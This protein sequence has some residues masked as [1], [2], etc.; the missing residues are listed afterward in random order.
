MGWT[1]ADHRAEQRHQDR[2]TEGIHKFGHNSAVGTSEEDIWDGASDAGTRTMIAAGATGAAVTLK[3]S[4][5]DTNDAMDITV[6]GLGPLF[7]AQSKTV[8]LNGFVETAIDGTWSRVY[9]AYQATGTADIAGDVYIYE[10]DATTNGVPDTATKIRAKILQGENQT[11]MAAYTIPAGMKG[12]V[13]HI[14]FHASSAIALSARLL[15]RKPG[16]NWRTQSK[17]GGLLSA[18]VSVRSAGGYYT[19]GTD[20][21]IVALVASSTVAVS[22]AFDVQLSKA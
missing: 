10:D 1:S 19:A 8:T 18:P 3:I 17:Y 4:S 2:P 16:V 13:S 7:V 11:L 14:E 15:A 12:Y 22:A 5:S 20:L 9:R 6:E 21:K